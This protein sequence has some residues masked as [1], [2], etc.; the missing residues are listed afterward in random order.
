MSDYDDFPMDCGPAI[1]HGAQWGGSLGQFAGGALGV[2]AAAQEGPAATIE[3]VGT[4]VGAMQLGQELGQGAGAFAGF[5]GCEAVN[6]FDSATQAVG[7]WY[8]DMMNPPQPEPAAAPAAPASNPDL[9]SAG[10]FG[11]SWGGF[12]SAFDSAASWGGSDMG[13]HSSPG[14]DSTGHQ[15]HSASSAHHDS[16]PGMGGDV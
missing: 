8:H 2:V 9:A 11:S 4:V 16:S 1:E 15:D 10:S 3:G 14:H 5:G 7:S 13:S 6:A 12:Q